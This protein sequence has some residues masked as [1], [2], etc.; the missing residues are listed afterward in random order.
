[1]TITKR[2]DNYALKEFFDTVNLIIIC[3][4]LLYILMKIGVCFMVSKVHKDLKKEDNEE[5]R[6]LGNSLH[7]DN[8]EIE[9]ANGKYIRFWFLAEIYFCRLG[10]NFRI[11]EINYDE[12]CF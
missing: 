1:M 6:Q 12:Y 10:T 8:V 5:K 3:L 7:H 2:Q 11:I 9:K 4:Y